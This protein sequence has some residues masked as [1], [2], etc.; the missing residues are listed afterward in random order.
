MRS[1]DLDLAYWNNYCK[2]I[3]GDDIG[4]PATDEVNKLYGGLDMTANNLLFLNSQEDPWQWASMRGV[5]H[6]KPS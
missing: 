3:F 1:K 4:Q 5:E 6:D 2:K